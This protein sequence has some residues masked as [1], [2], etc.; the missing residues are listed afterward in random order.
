M[1]HQADG[2]VRMRFLAPTRGLFGFRS[3][4]L[5]GTR[6]TGTMYHSFDHFGPWKGEISSRARG[7]LVAFETGEATAY[8]IEHA[9]ERGELFI[10]P[11]DRVYRGMIV[12]E[13]ARPGDLM[14]NVAKKKQLTNIRSSTQEIAVK[15]NAPR[16]MTLEKALE[17]IADDELLE[18]T[19]K[20]FRMRKKQLP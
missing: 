16:L 11:G 7:S 17:F 4:F 2:R 13:H 9:Q 3:E 1:D 14:I 10:K 8:G 18:V 12:G 6:G 5:T 20:H 19:P 15:L